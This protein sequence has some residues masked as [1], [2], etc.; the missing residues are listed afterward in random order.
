MCSSNKIVFLWGSSHRY[1][2]FAYTEN[3]RRKIIFKLRQ[4]WFQSVQEIRRYELV[5]LGVTFLSFPKFRPASIIVH[6]SMVFYVFTELVDNENDP[7]KMIFKVRQT[8][9]T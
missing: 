5:K 9:S 6:I 8:W 3:D 4:T 2:R 1:G 7:R